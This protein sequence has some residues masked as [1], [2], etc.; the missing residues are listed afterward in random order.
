MVLGDRGGGGPGCHCRVVRQPELT[1][2]NVNVPA[3]PPAQMRG[4]RWAKVDEFGHFNVAS[5]SQGGTA[6][7]LG[8]R[9]RSTGTD[10]DSDTAL[11]LDGYVTLTLL[12]PLEAKPAPDDDADVVTG[13]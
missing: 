13:R 2:L 1:V 3:V 6:L 8:V 7:D 9:D 10:P 4:S 5:Q 12:S 11:C